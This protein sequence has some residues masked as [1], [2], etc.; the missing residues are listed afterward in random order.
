MGGH[1]KVRKYFFKF[2]GQRFRNSMNL[3]W[4]MGFLLMAQSRI[5]L[6]KKLWWN[7]SRRKVSQRKVLVSFFDR[8][9]GISSIGYF[10]QN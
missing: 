8:I 10:I 9:S 5:I 4:K 6:D 2:F 1:I 7:I 3:M